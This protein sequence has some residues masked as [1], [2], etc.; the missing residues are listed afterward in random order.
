MSTLVEETRAPVRPAARVRAT[1]ATVL[2]GIGL[3]LL[4][5]QVWTI[6]GWL[7]DGPSQITTERESGTTSWYAARVLEVLILVS[8]VAIAAVVARRCLRE[9]RLTT[10]AML[11]AGMG[12]AAFWDPI[13]N[14]ITPAWLYSSNWI[15]VNDWFAHAP[16][17]LNPDAGRMP[18][19]IVPVLIGYSFWGVGFAMLVNV[20]M[21]RARDRWPAISRAA[22][23][24]VAFVVSGI[25]TA[26]AFN[27]FRAFDLMDAPGYRLAILGDSLSVFFFYSGG[28][29][30]GAVACLRFFADD[31][32]RIVTQRGLETIA[33]RRRGAVGLLA[34]MAAC[35]LIVV[36]GWGLMTV[37]ASLYA[38]PYPETPKHLING[39]C[40]APGVSGTSYGPCPGS[41]GFRV[42][43]K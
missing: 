20:M 29:V 32:G 19:P 42:P 7:A 41:P 6:T 40:D 21:R 39:L 37:P 14:W 15:N 17:V 16:L 23:V 10:D 13:Y 12:S 33:P 24:A 35:Q 18:W 43:I 30:F 27:V 8:T 34:T 31:H 3:V 36:L 28:L 9:R 26:L 5:Y 4:A 38:S 22:L 1:P 11:I 25:V 2:A